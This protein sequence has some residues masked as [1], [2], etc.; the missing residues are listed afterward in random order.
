MDDR[1]RQEDWPAGCVDDD[2]DRWPACPFETDFEQDCDD[3]QARVFPGAGVSCTPGD[4]WD[5]NG[6]DDT[7]QD[8]GCQPADPANN[9]PASPA[10]DDDRPRRAEWPAG[11]VDADGDFWP[12]CP[13]ETA[14]PQDCDDT[15]ARRYP[16]AGVSCT[17]GDDWD[18]DGQDDTQQPNGCRAADPANNRPEQ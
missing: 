9:R 8:S 7:E 13:F 5:C 17:P 15:E 18:C 10:A 4:D 2:G 14:F 11:C 6:Q 1:P 3:G 16:H 12:V